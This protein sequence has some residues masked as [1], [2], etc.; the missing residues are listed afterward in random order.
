M[1]RKIKLEINDYQG[2]LVKEDEL[3]IGDGDKLIIS[4]AKEVSY[5]EL[6]AL[7]DLTKSVLENE[8]QNIL[9]IHEGVRLKILKVN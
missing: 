4:T 5:K 2:N 6:V 9:M 8:D 3:I 1:T 7:F